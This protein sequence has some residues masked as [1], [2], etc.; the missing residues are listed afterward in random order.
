MQSRIYLI[1]ADQFGGLGY[2]DTED[3]VDH[4]AA[5]DHVVLNK[6]DLAGVQRL[7][8]IAD[9]LAKSAPRALVH[10]TSYGKLSFEAFS[11]SA[12]KTEGEFDVPQGVHQPS[13]LYETFA[14]EKF[15][16]LPRDRLA[17]LT[18]SMK[19]MCLRAT[20]GGF[21]DDAPEIPVQLQLVGERLDMNILKASVNLSSRLVTI[22]WAEKMD[23]HVL[24]KLIA[25]EPI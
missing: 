21:L 22:G 15:P 13:T 14:F 12:F 5:S 20:G 19:R 18:K 11:M 25:M 7:T 2:A 16:P 8:E 1:D 23:K 3:L 6:S 17:E 24:S 4:A 10:R 9:L